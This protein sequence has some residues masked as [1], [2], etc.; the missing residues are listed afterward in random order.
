MNGHRGSGEHTHTLLMPNYAIDHSSF[1]L[2]MPSIPTPDRNRIT[3]PP[4]HHTIITPTMR[5]QLTSI[6]QTVT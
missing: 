5:L 3:P 2:F 4:S 6:H 1:T